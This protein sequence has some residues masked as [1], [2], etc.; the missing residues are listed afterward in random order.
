[1]ITVG[2][3][4]V[5]CVTSWIVVSI[6]FAPA[7]QL[8]ILLGMVMPLFVASW[9]LVFTERAYRRDPSSLTPFM[10]KAFIGKIMVIGFYIVLIVGILA[11]K[12]APFI[13]SFTAYFVALHFFEALCLRRLFRAAV[14][15]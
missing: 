11:L 5:G 6:M 9:S 14:A 7:A 13:F 1:M 15:Q 8:E 4:T 12:A 2:L 10:L 3:M